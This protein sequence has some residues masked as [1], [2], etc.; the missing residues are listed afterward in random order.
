MSAITS[1][2]LANAIVKLVAVDILNPLVGELIMGNLVNRDFEAVLA[3][4]GDTVNVPIPPSMV[5]NDLIEGGTVQT[6]NPNLGNA[7]IV[8]DKHKEAT[9]TIPDVTKVIGHPQLLT[10]YMKPA[11]IAIVEAVEKDLLKKW[12]YLDANTPVGAAGT[13]LTEVTLDAAETALFKAKVPR[14]EDKYLVVSAEEYATLRQIARFSEVDKYGSGDAIITG[15]VGKLKDF[16]IFRSQ[17]VDKT[18]TS[19]VNTHN[20]AFAKDAIALAT[21]R[22]PKP[23]PGTGAI[24]EYSEMG[25]FG[26]RITMSYEPNT[27]A[28]QFTVDILYGAGILR[29]T[30]GIQVNS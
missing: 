14:S 29:N 30:H 7:A 12:S 25:N 17:Y 16:S 26:V 1:A 19:P 13:G 24:A 21:R 23:L 10:A 22:L 6:Q 11:I 9:F 15:K 8:L 5:A 27:L 3:T 20:L 28:Q 4:A 18:G 2:N